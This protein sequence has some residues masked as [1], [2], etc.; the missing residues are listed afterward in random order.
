MTIGTLLTLFVVP[1]VY[2]LVGRVHQAETQA[3]PAQ[4]PAAVPA[5]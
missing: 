2:S 4:I 1:A 5:E 3:V